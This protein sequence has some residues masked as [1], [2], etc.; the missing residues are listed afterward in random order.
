MCGLRSKDFAHIDKFDGTFSQY[1]DWVERMEAK[2]R[3]IHPACPT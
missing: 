2:L 3:R 1:A